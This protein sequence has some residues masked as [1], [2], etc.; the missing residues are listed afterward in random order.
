MG[1]S[2]K[3]KVTTFFKLKRSW[4]VDIDSHEDLAVASAMLKIKKND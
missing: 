4:P 1:N 3:K 2:T